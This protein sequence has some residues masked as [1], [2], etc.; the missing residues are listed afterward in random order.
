[1]L[2]SIWHYFGLNYRLKLKENIIYLSFQ[3]LNH[4]FDAVKSLQLKALQNS[5]A[6]SRRIGSLIG[7]LLPRINVNNFSEA[8]FNFSYVSVFTLCRFR[9]EFW[10]ASKVFSLFFF[11]VARVPQGILNWFATSLLDLPFSSS[12]NAS[13]FT[14]EVEIT[15]YFLFVAIFI[16]SATINRIQTSLRIS[17]HSNIMA[18]KLKQKMKELDSETKILITWWKIRP[19]DLKICLI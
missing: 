14:F 15:S 10:K 13:Y 3:P 12:Y 5:W 4:T 18:F 19:G 16:A 2:Q 17:K 7:M 9:D 8:S 1:M 11:Q 6:F